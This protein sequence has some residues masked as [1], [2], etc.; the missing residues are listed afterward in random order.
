MQ[1]AA[2]LRTKITGFEYTDVVESA[3][4]PLLSKRWLTMFRGT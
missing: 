1:D 4:K 3:I 2:I